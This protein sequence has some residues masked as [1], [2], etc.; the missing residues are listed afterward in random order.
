MTQSTSRENQ[1]AQ[2]Q[3]MRHEPHA[4]INAT[5]CASPRNEFAEDE[6]NEE[7]IYKE[8]EADRAFAE[9]LQKANLLFQETEGESSKR[10][11]AQVTPAK[12]QRV[13]QTPETATMMP[14]RYSETYP[15]IKHSKYFEVGYER[16][17]ILLW[18]KFEAQEWDR[19]ILQQFRMWAYGHWPK[20][21][22]ELLEMDPDLTQ[23]ERYH[24]GRVWIDEAVLLGMEQIHLV[25]GLP[26]E[27]NREIKSVLRISTKI[28]DN[29]IRKELSEGDKM[30]INSRGIFINRIVDDGRQWAAKILITW[31]CNT[32]RPTDL[33]KG[34]FRM[35]RAIA[36]P[37]A[38]IPMGRVLGG[39]ATHI[40]PTSPDTRSF[41]NYDHRQ[42]KIVHEQYSVMMSNWQDRLY[43]KTF[44]KMREYHRQTR[45]LL[46]EV[47][48]ES[49]PE[50]IN[51]LG[52]TSAKGKKP[53]QD[54]EKKKS[55]PTKKLGEGETDQPRNKKRKRGKEEQQ[56]QKKEIR[57]G[58]S[59]VGEGQQSQG[60]EQQGDK[61]QQ[62]DV[63]ARSAPTTQGNPG[64]DPQEQQQKPPTNPPQTEQQQ[65]PPIDTPQ[66]QEQTPLSGGS[67][68]KPPSP[69]K[70]K[71][72]QQQQ[73]SQRP[74]D[75]PIR[76]ERQGPSASQLPSTTKSPS[77]KQRPMGVLGRIGKTT[78]GTPLGG[79][80]PCSVCP[81]P[82][83]EHF[84]PV[85]FA[86]HQ[87]LHCRGEDNHH[88]TTG[89]TDVGV[90]T[91]QSIG[92][93]GRQ[94]SAKQG[95]TESFVTYSSYTEAIEAMVMEAKFSGQYFQ[96]KP[97]I[98]QEALGKVEQAKAVVEEIN[99]QMDVVEDSTCLKLQYHRAQ[100]A[101]IQ[102]QGDT[103]RTI[104]ILQ[105]YK[106]K[107]ESVEQQVQA[108]AKVFRTHLQELKKE[109]DE[110]EADASSVASTTETHLQS[111]AQI[112]KEW[113]Q[114]QME[115]SMALPKAVKKT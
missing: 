23:V 29:E 96:K 74:A 9:A 17:E 93:H 16:R 14:K 24:D 10:S 53:R 41:C 26:I 90:P 102:T 6:F 1:K 28:S 60:G 67:Q 95:A 94:E 76:Q 35:I 69:M 44:L 18:M 61:Q 55:S 78:E 82:G 106:A 85:E 112:T 51:I 84:G 113:L 25:S 54:K 30:A 114:L 13:V 80:Q 87:L 111:V 86:C 43:A 65:Q 75:P 107:V 5:T 45:K 63:G 8:D 77:K 57:Q 88:S 70:E 81:R 22:M 49:L 68:E 83:Q 2:E 58:E 31:F 46:Q 103:Y 101:Y 36:D 21:W 47:P 19:A 62:Q 33:P 4:A 3:E 73:E 105:H 99:K 98:V 66:T 12:E 91:S 110:G 97:Q 42:P 89:E 56:K 15:A 72:P 59:A 38:C 115:L 100:Q 108:Q 27:A 104:G 32:G 37:R 71:D 11:R 64:G 40:H 7:T 20:N 109:V 50:P 34:W 52:E 92:R 79:R 39:I 48:I